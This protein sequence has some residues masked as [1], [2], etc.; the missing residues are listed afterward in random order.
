[1][2]FKFDILYYSIEE[3]DLSGLGFPRTSSISISS[4]AIVYGIV[5]FGAKKCGVAKVPGVYT[6]VKNYIPWIL[7]HMKGE[8]HFRNSI[9]LK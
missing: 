8:I 3:T 4:N 9:K 1:M 7:S 6:L 5:S 2:I